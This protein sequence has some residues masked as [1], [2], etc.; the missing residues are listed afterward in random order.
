MSPPP[1]LNKCQ[2]QFLPH[3]PD[4]VLVFSIL[5]FLVKCWQ[6]IKQP[7]DRRNTFYFFKSPLGSVSSSCSTKKELSPSQVHTHEKNKK[8]K[9][10]LKSVRTRLERLKSCTT[11]VSSYRYDI[12]CRPNHQSSV[13]I[14]LLGPT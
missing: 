4:R 7:M 6:K 13:P 5:N 1:L 8:E 9:N 11:L 2:N 14:C 3:H 10:G 12:L